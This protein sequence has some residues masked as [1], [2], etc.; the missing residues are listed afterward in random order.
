[1]KNDVIVVVVAIY[2][3]AF[4]EKLCFLLLLFFGYLLSH[5]LAKQ[6]DDDNNRE[7]FRAKNILKTLHYQIRKPVSKRNFIWCLFSG[8]FIG[9]AFLYGCK[10]SHYFHH[11]NR[12]KENWFTRTNSYNDY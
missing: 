3:N 12:R 1:M 8:R 2:R 6:Q 9:L 4:F 10:I 7:T 11:L 5:T